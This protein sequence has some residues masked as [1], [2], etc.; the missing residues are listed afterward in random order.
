[1][2]EVLFSQGLTAL[3]HTLVLA[4]TLLEAGAGRSGFCWAEERTSRAETASAPVEMV[5]AMGANPAPHSQ[6]ALDGK[7]HTGVHLKETQIR[8]LVSCAVSPGSPGGRGDCD[9]VKQGGLIGQ[10]ELGGDR[11]DGS[12]GQGDWEGDRRKG[13]RGPGEGSLWEPLLHLCTGTGARWPSGISRIWTVT[14]TTDE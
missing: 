6:L 3:P 5:A 12:R 7:T 4:H 9:G 10:G 13:S 1:M 2:W 14:Q 11:S 8:K